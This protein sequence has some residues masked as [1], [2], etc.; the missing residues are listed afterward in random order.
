MNLRFDFG[1]KWP[2]LLAAV[3]VTDA[4]AD[5]GERYKDFLKRNPVEEDSLPKDESGLWRIKHAIGTKNILVTV[6]E[7]VICEERYYSVNRAE[8][9]QIVQQQFRASLQFEVAGPDEV[10]WRSKDR[11]FAARFSNKGRYLQIS[12]VP[13]VEEQL[14]KY[15][16]AKL[17]KAVEQEEK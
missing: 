1:M 4:L 16:K 6:R 2:L 7:G 11:Q 13:V 3:C 12:N 5:V 14:E 9:E 8:A 17:I 15:R 10:R